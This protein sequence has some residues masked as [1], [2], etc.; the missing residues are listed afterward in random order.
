[1]LASMVTEGQRL[2]V[3]IRDFLDIQRLEHQR[4]R[5]V[6]QP[7]DLRPL[8]EHAATIAR[9]DADHRLLVDVPERLP[10]VQVDPHRLQQVLANLLSNARKY[11]P[12]AKFDWQRASSKVGLS[13][14]SL[15]TGWA[16]RPR[17]CRGCLKS[18]IVLGARS[19]ATFRARASGWQL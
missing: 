4:L 18:S 14:R 5:I 17:R 1:M 15:T 16:S 6:P 11:T 3:I 19:V 13:S 7:L 12:A 9:S 8:L 2:N 10:R